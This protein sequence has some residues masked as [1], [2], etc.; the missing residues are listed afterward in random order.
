MRI[1]VRGSARGSCDATTQ[2]RFLVI[3]GKR[4]S[5]PSAEKCPAIVVP[6]GAA[7]IPTSLVCTCSAQATAWTSNG[8]A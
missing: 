1:E 6:G 8:G 7:K 4:G 2:R 3:S 5:C